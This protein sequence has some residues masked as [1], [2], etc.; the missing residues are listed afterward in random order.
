MELE[1]RHLRV[2]C[3]LADTGSVSKAAASMSVSQPSLTAQLRRIEAAVGGQ[4]FQRGVRGVV[5]TP[6][7]KHILGRARVLLADMDDLVNSSCKYVDTGGP[8]R[9]GSVNTVT[10]VSWLTRLEEQLEGREIKAQVDP[11]CGVLT[12]LLEADVLDIVM[13][14][15]CDEAHAPPCPVGIQEQ[16]MVD[17]EPVLI[18]MAADHRLAGRSVIRLTDLADETW[19]MPPG[20]KRDGNLAAL[21]AA[22]EAVGF[23]PGF[24]YDALGEAEVEQFVSAGRGIVTAAPT[25]GSIPNT[26]GLP[27]ADHSLGLRRVLRWRPERVPPELVD[28]VHRAFTGAYREILA[29]RI[30]NHPWWPAT[31]HA[32]PVIHEPFQD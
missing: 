25:V 19:L 14:M 17:P 30:P 1:L 29:S 15:L 24:R 20:G 16:A 27:L 7:G 32:H 2:V 26:V 23:T 10:F 31:P 12:D 13:L 21:R 5:P 11:S 4:L 18:V 9:L 3:R 28:K 6:L 22:C 8:L